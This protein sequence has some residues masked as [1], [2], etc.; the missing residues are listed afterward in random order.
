MNASVGVFLRD[1]QAVVVPR[2]GGYDLDAV[3]VVK[4]IDQ[5]LQRAI[6]EAVRVSSTAEMPADAGSDRWSVLEALGLTSARAFYHNVAHVA[7]LVLQGNLQ[8]WPCD[9][10]ARGQAFEAVRPAI[11]VADMKTIGAITL[12]ALQ[13]SPRMNPKR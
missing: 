7:V 10:T 3:A 8:V 1:D 9:P 13:E 4:P 5:D 11:S 12:K 2:A 6:E